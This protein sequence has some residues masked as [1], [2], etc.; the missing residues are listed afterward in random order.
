MKNLAKFAVLGA[1]LALAAPFA[2]ATAFP[3]PVGTLNLAGATLVAS[4]GGS[5]TASTGFQATWTENVYKNVAGTT[6][7]TFVYTLSN[8]ATVASEIGHESMLG[9]GNGLVTS[10]FQVAT[11]TD[12]IS[13][14]DLTFGI[15]NISFTTPL[16]N[17]NTLNELVVET[18]APF[19]ASAEIDFIDGTTSQQTALVPAVEPEPSSLILFGT[20][21]ISTGGMLLRRRKISA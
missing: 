10:A 17:G 4:T 5:P 15:V 12:S 13:G 1:A 16:I 19:F 21:L 8:T 11:G 2:S 6:G 20:G 3:V 7:L 9:Y 14:G 18:N